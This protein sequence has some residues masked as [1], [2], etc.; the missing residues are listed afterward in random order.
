M[1]EVLLPNF[2]AVDQ[3]QADF[4]FE[5]LD[6]CGYKPFLHIRIYVQE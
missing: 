2:R 6:E 5:K 3:T 4:E 1:M